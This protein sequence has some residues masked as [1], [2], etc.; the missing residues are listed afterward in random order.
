MV[1]INIHIDDEIRKEIY[2]SY[3][4]KNYHTVETVVNDIIDRFMKKQYFDPKLEFKK[5]DYKKCGFC[6]EKAK[7]GRMID[8]DGMNLVEHDVCANCG[9]GQPELE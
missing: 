4:K 2:R 9:S 5:S 6:E 3:R 8:I 7:H 1:R